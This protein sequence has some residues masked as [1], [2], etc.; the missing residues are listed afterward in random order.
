MPTD[1][2][3]VLLC[4]SEAGAQIASDG[5]AEL[6]AVGGHSTA[7]PSLRKVGVVDWR[8]LFSRLVTWFHSKQAEINTSLYKDA[9][10]RESAGLPPRWR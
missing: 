3:S 7:L 5:L 1:T 6:T 2:A 8:K 4:N 9:Q 10:R